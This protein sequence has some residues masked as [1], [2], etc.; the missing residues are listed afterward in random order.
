MIAVAL[1]PLILSSCA[2]DLKNLRIAAT[3]TG[4]AQA[5]VSLPDMPADCRAK[6]AHAPLAVGL[7]AVSVLK[8]ERAA[9]DRQNARTGRCNGSGGWYDRLQEEIQ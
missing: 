2:N 5:R 4:R 7:H 1:T 6:E 9:L 8:R 3:E